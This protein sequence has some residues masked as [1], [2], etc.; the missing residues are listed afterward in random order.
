MI[1]LARSWTE[2]QDILRK[3]AKSLKDIFYFTFLLILFLFIMSLLGMELFANTCREY[4]DGTLV[5]DV[6]QATKLGKVLITPRANFDS[7]SDAMVTMFIIILGED[8]PGIMYNY[9]RVYGDNGWPISIFFMTCFAIGNFM[10]LSL[11]VA[12][13]LSNFENSDDEEE[14]EE[15]EEVSN[16]MFESTKNKKSFS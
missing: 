7:I 9:V 3:I 16:S 11:F 6:Q 4:P 10:L 2:L 12:I 5:K 13:L 15:D 14:D 8:W 1:K